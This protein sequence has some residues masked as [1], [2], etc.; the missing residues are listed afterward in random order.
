MSWKRENT[1]ICCAFCWFWH[2]II[3][4]EK[5]Q[6]DPGSLEVDRAGG[7]G[8]GHI[9]YIYIYRDMYIC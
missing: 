3:L 6:L 1:V 8:S 4:V 2:A 7:V 5:S 9:Q